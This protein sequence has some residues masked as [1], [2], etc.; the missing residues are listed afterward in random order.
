MVICP[1]TAGASVSVGYSTNET[2]E[3]CP[4]TVKKDKTSVELCAK[5]A[6]KIRRKAYNENV[7]QA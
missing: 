2:P 4:S 7:C 3:L 6:W 5:I 1:N